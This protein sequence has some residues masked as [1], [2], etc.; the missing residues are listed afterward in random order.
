MCAV[1]GSQCIVE[2]LFFHAWSG[3]IGFVDVNQV[4]VNYMR[5]L[6]TKCFEY[7]VDFRLQHSSKH[8][9]RC[10]GQD[11]LQDVYP[12]V[13]DHPEH[14][15]RLRRDDISGWLGYKDS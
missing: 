11:L 4:T 14:W 1:G 12:G 10:Q 7:D 13:F 3:G 15:F 5:C 9:E 6:C 2:Q 8:C